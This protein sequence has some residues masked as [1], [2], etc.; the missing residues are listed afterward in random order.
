MRFC[1]NKGGN[2]NKRNFSGVTL[3]CLAAAATVLILAGC[4]SS[5]HP[6]PLNAAVVSE[7]QPCLPGPST[8]SASGT[9]GEAIPSVPIAPQYPASALFQGIEGYVTLEFTIRK[10][11]RT[12]DARVLNSKPAGLFDHAAIQALAR[13]KFE[14]KIVNGKPV[15][16]RATFKYTFCLP[17]NRDRQHGQSRPEGCIGSMLQREMVSLRDIPPP[18]KS[19]APASRAPGKSE[20]SQSVQKAVPVVPVEPDYPTTAAYTKTEGAV[21]LSFTIEPDGTTCDAK[22]VYSH[23]AGVFEF[24]ALKALTASKFKPKSVKNGAVA[25]RASFLYTFTLPDQ[26]DGT[27]AYTLP[28]NLASAPPAYPAT[29][30]LN[31]VKGLVTLTFTVDKQGHTRHPVVIDS[32]P[33]GLF[34]KA[35]ISALLRSKFKIKR[36]DGKPVSYKARFTYKF[37]IKPHA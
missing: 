15:P 32:A 34:D 10:D 12:C 1:H 21:L 13:S 30:I 18:C 25:S 36:V 17:D 22:I 2:V 31:H 37:R 4:A 11:G 6:A 26:P 33:A 28:E 19:E 9:A 3:S 7:G 16:S 29:D 23:P 14:P 5:P 20:S 35:A 24:S 27:N 8:S